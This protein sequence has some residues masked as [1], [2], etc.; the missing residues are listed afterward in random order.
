MDG[1]LP[2]GWRTRRLAQCGREDACESTRATT[3]VARRAATKRVVDDQ[4][5]D[6]AHDGHEQALKVETAH[7]RHSMEVSEGSSS[8]ASLRVVGEIQTGCYR[9]IFSQEFPDTDFMSVGIANDSIDRSG[10]TSAMIR[11]VAAG[12]SVVRLIDR[13]DRS[14]AEI[15]D[16]RQQGVRVLS[17]RHLESYLFADEILTALCESCGKSD[18]ASELLDAKAKALEESRGRGNAT[19]DMKSA[20]GATYNAIKRL[21][22]P[23]SPGSTYRVFMREVLARQVTP[24]TTTY[25]RLR[26]DV[27]PTGGTPSAPNP[28][29]FERAQWAGSESPPRSRS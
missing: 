10:R 27:F 15:A 14:E 8:V 9:T 6:G 7:S 16:L 11:A 4:H 17:E 2:E 13:D 5:R 29:Q 12:T 1:E 23:P 3:M 21:L 19:D 20:A 24:A 18:R 25:G 26:Q 22:D 28:T